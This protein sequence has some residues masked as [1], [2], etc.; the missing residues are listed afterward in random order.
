M[1]R[2]YEL[3]EAAEQ[4]L[5]GITRYTRNKWGAQQAARYIKELEQGMAAV[6]AGKH[7]F[8]DI[9]DL[10]PGLRVRR[11]GHHHIFCRIQD[12]YRPQIIAILHERMDL[13][14]RLAAR[15]Q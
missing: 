12:G 10:R 1:K 13:L 3:L 5:R 15:L 7:P 14:A 2:A 11:C 4:D 8:R 6:A 9:G